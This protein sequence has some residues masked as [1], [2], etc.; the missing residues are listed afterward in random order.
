MQMEICQWLQ[1]LWR[2]R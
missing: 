1:G 2:F